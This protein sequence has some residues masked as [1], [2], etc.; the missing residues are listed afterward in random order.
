MKT[1]TTTTPASPKPTL[2]DYYYGQCWIAAHNSWN[3]ALSPANNQQYTITELLNYG[4]RGFALDIWGDKGHLHL[5]HGNDNP[6]SANNWD[7]IRDELKDWMAN[8]PNEIVT[9]FFESYLNGPIQGQS[10][11]SPLEELSDSLGKIDSYVTGR[12]DQ[13]TAI[14]QKTIADMIT[15]NQ[16]LYA[17]LEEEPK[18]GHQTLFPVMRKLFA[19]NHYGADSVDIHSWNRIRQDSNY[20]NPLTFMNHF[21]DSPAISDN[22][23]D[24]IFKHT[25]DFTF[26][27]GGRR[28]MFIS[29]DNI[30]ASKKGQGVIEV[31]K[32]I[33]AA[34][35]IISPFTF[36]D[37]EKDKWNDVDM[38]MDRRPIIDFKLSSAGGKG[39]TR[40]VAIYQGG[41]RKKP[42]VTE[43][44][45]LQQAGYGIVNMRFRKASDKDW[46]KWQTQFGRPGDSNTKSVIHTAKGTFVGICSRRE[47][48]YGVTD[49]AFASPL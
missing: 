36:T 5:Q 10:T 48:N 20:K 28:P 32:K 14:M 2:T 21:R 39:I 37:I 27:F 11:S 17:F 1:T 38:Y 42:A 33:P 40:I 8:N 45:L 9:L 46:G 43:V 30:D 16:R 26:N 34:R 29:L 18:Q 44:Q 24:Q 31:L 13:E 4:V 3:T 23:V 19:E 12:T 6:A 15:A 41:G 22:S 47:G 25:R 35:Y 49:V 7:N